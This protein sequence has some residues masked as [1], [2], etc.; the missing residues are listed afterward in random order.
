MA[1]PRRCSHS[2][3][4][5]PGRSGHPAPPV[6]TALGQHGVNIMEF[7]KQYNDAT[8]QMGGQATSSSSRIYEDRSF[9][10]ITKQP[11]PPS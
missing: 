10:F 3:S 2:S 5:D 6:G 9:S 8:Q 4:C 11:L 7:C 1:K